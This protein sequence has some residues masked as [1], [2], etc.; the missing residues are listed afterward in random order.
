MIILSHAVNSAPAFNR[1]SIDGVAYTDLARDLTFTDPSSS[2][3]LLD[4]EDGT[5]EYQYLSKYHLIGKV[6]STLS[7]CNIIW[8]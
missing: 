8:I 7:Q 5:F 1:I 3:R 2:W 4:N 6:F